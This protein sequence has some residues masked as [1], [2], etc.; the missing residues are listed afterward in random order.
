MLL[1]M[2]RLQNKT[3]DTRETNIFFAKVQF[4]NE[5]SNSIITNKIE[6]LFSLYPKRKFFH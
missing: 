6:A 3:A 5:N 2:K 1:F 4:K